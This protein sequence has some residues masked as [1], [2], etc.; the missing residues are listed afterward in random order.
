MFMRVN[1]SNI[2][3]GDLSKENAQGGWAAPVH[4]PPP[5]RVHNCAVTAVRATL[6]HATC[7]VY[8]LHV[9]TEGSVHGPHSDCAALGP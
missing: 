9:G 4:F 1:K 5:T 2:L 3:L 6:K 8:M 7:L